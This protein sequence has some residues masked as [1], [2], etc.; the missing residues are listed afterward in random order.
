MTRTEL[1]APAPRPVSFATI[2]VIL[3]GLGLFL[4]LT[5]WAIHRHHHHL[6]T[7]PA[8]G[9][10]EGTPKEAA[11]QATAEGR[12]AYL[13]DLKAKQQKELA[14]YGWVD[15]KAGVVQLPIDRAMALVAQEHSAAK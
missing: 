5:R 8:Y 13:L 15:R 10:A 14:A 12:R 3:A 6:H 7:L 11:W 2:V 4:F 9:S 1:T